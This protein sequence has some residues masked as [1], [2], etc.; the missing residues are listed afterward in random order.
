ML[1]SKQL[2]RSMRTSFETCSC[3]DTLLVLWEIGKWTVIKV[4]K[5]GKKHLKTVGITTENDDSAILQSVAF[6]ISN[7]TVLRYLI[8][9]SK[10]ANL[11]LI[12]APEWRVSTPPHP[13]QVKL[14][15]NMCWLNEEFH[16][17]NDRALCHQVCLLHLIMS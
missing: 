10:M 3:S 15:S 11:R 13:T 8:W 16:H 12:S 1:L 4:L 2:F 7:M 5:S 17:Q 9:I 6:V 14:L